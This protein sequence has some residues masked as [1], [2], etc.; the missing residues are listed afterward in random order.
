MDFLD[1]FFPEQAQATHL[2]SIARNTNMARVASAKVRGQS[3]E[4]AELQDDVRF[5]TLVL[6]AVIKR[7]TETET[8]NLADVQDLLDEIDRLDGAADG[9]LEPSVLRGI[10]GLLKQE[11]RGESGEGND[12][13]QIQATPRYRNRQ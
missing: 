9:N 10:L 13:F 11:A 5:L 3:G 4:L 6:A 8:M 1:F 7:L 12:E 2:R